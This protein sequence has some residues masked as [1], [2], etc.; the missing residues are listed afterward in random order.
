MHV[1]LIILSLNQW[2]NMVAYII[3]YVL[4]HAEK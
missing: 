3:A 4:M 1:I 2:L